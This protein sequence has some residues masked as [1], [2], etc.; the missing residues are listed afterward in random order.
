MCYMECCPTHEPL[1]KAK[2]IFQKKKKSQSLDW[3]VQSHVASSAMAARSPWKTCSLTEALSHILV[4]SQS[5]ARK[6]VLS[7]NRACNLPG[8][9]ARKLW[10][11]DTHTEQRLYTVNKSVPVPQLSS[12]CHPSPSK[13]TDVPFQLLQTD[14]EIFPFTGRAENRLYLQKGLD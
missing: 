12:G 3:V 14:S 7:L 8:I 4:Q 5:H 2:Q 13:G 10:R 9:R 11:K 6:A 1:S